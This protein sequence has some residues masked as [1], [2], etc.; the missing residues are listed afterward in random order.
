LS[1][2]SLKKQS[3]TLRNFLPEI[4][5]SA[6]KLLDFS[7]D[8]D[9]TKHLRLQQQAASTT[10]TTSTAVAA[11]ARQNQKINKSELRRRHF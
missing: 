9:E 1:N 8:I 5:V 4:R 3:K 6:Y 10:T 11:A 2:T 7:I